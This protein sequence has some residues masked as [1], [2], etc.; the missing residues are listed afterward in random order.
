MRTATVAAVLSRGGDSA[1]AAAGAE[2]VAAG[3]EIAAAAHAVGL[4]IETLSPRTS[5][6][7]ASEAVAFADE[8]PF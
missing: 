5:C 6:A 8:T 1:G 4:V 2:I 3:V 7:V